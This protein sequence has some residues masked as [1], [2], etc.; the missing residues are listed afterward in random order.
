M[1]NFNCSYRLAII[2]TGLMLSLT[3]ALNAKEEGPYM[4]S[5]ITYW[6][7]LEAPKVDTQDLDD[8]SEFGPFPP[9][10]YKVDGSRAQAFIGVGYNL[11]EQWGFEVFYVSTPE[12]LLYTEEFEVPTR[13][14]LHSIN[15]SW[16]TTVQHTIFGLAAVYDVYLHESFSVF[17][18]A[19]LAFLK[20]KADT[21][22][23]FGGQMNP[24]PST[25]YLALIEEE[26]T[27]DVFGAIGAR[28][29]F[30]AGDASLTVAYQFIET[31]DDRETSIEVGIQWNF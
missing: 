31:S 15:F 13:Y 9:F 22:I 20:H 1:K 4:L 6:N 14:P 11:D 28:I 19:G 16:R 12:R 17:G 8:Q 21:S 24:I 7:D 25:H 23:T 10:Q 5:G 3:T 26:D 27:T 18:K 30:R 29:P 2:A